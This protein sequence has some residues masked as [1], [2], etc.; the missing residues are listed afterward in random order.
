MHRWCKELLPGKHVPRACGVLLVC[1]IHDH[2]ASSRFIVVQAGYLCSANS[3]CLP[4]PQGSFCPEGSRQGSSCPWVADCPARAAY[5]RFSGGRG[6]AYILILLL[7]LLSH[8]AFCYWMHR[9]RRQLAR[10]QLGVTHPSSLHS[11]LSLLQA[12]D[13]FERCDKESNKLSAAM[14]ILGLPCLSRMV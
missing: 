11:R 8:V 9:R 7:L 14:D 2:V 4:C 12:T 13:G 3:T 1:C 5:P 10:S 6:F